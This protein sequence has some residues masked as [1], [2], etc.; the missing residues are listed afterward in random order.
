MGGSG[1]RVSHQPDAHGNPFLPH[2]C[3]VNS[4]SQLT[5]STH[6]VNSRRQLTPSTH[7]VD[8]PIS[9]KKRIFK[10]GRGR[11]RAH[12]HRTGRR[13][14]VKESGAEQ[15]DALHVLGH[16]E[17]VEAAQRRQPPARPRGTSGRPGRRPPGR[18]PRRRP[19]AG[20]RAATRPTTSAP[21]PVRGGSST[22]RSTGPAIRRRWPARVSTRP[23]PPRPGAGR[24]GCAG[25]RRRRA[26][27]DSTRVTRPV[28][29]PGRRERRGEQAGSAVQVPGGLARGAARAGRARRRPG[30]PRPPGVPARRR[31]RAAASSPGRAA[32]SRTRCRAADRVGAT[33]AAA[34]E[35]GDVAAGGGDRLDRVHVRPAPAAAAPAVPGWPGGRSGTGRSAPPRASGA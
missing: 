25:P 11:G 27:A 30:C 15:A 20:R 22:T 10:Q 6:A 35:H 34:C 14:A 1:G 4:R 28:G 13:Q 23:A 19:R 32:T 18:R 7:A 2:G 12:V 29:R 16:R 17:Q 3:A 21:A 33:S 31:R 26:A 24:A 8:S 9:R 5:P